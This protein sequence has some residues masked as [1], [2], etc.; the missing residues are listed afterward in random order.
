MF[1]GLVVARAYTS[2]SKEY[3]YSHDGFC[4]EHRLTLCFLCTV[5]L[6]WLI[7]FFDFSEYI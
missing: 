7:F 6:V 1:T 3:R 5:L 4:V 2:R